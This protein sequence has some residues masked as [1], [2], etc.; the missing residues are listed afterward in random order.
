MTDLSHGQ[1]FKS[2]LSTRDRLFAGVNV[3]KMVSGWE[4]RRNF[5]VKLHRSDFQLKSHSSAVTSSSTVTS[6]L[7]MDFLMNQVHLWM[8][9]LEA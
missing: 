9:R 5:A 2:Y 6:F 4:Q 7:L 8:N 1:S 3:E